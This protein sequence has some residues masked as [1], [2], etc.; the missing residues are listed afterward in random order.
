MFFKK[1]EIHGFKSFCHRTIIS[2]DKALTIIVGPN[3]CGKSNIFDG[4]RWVL[5]E[6]S[7]KSLRGGRMGDVIFNGSATQRPMGFAKVSLTVMNERKILPIDFSE[8]DITRRLF[9]NGEST[10]LLNKKACRLKDITE[11][12][13]DTGAGTS[14]YSIM[15]QG[16]VDQIISSK[17]LERRVIFEEAAGITKYKAKKEEAQRKLQRTEEDHLRITD[18]LVELKKQVGSLKR[19]ANKA[20]RYKELMESL[21]K[22]EMQLL[23]MRFLELVE[24]SK[25]VESN[26]DAKSNELIEVNTIITKLEADQSETSI[27]SETVN[28]KLLESTNSKFEI[29]NNIEKCQSSL[30]LNN[31][32]IKNIEELVEKLT[33][34]VSQLK[35]QEKIQVE[36]IAKLSKESEELE[37][38]IKEEDEKHTEILKRF[39]VSKEALRDKIELKSSLVVQIRDKQISINN[40]N[41]ELEVSAK[42]NTQYSGEKKILEKQKKEVGDKLTEVKAFLDEER[43]DIQS[44]N[45]EISNCEK[46]E[47]KIDEKV[48]SLSESIKQSDQKL[49]ELYSEKRTFES[50]LKAL[51]E[52]QESYAGFSKGVKTVLSATQNGSLKGIC[53]V[54]ASLITTEEKYEIAIESALGSGMQ[55]I[56]TENSED[57]KNA[58]DYLRSKNAGKATFL[59]LD[60]IEPFKTKKTSDIENQQGVLGWA[61]DLVEFDDKFKKIA[62]YLLG[63]VVIVETLE[64][65]I[66]LEK[67]GIR[68]R[69]VSLEGDILNP[70]GSM[71]GGSYIKSGI[72]GRERELK[73]YSR[74]VSRLEGTI[75]NLQKEVDSEK[76]KLN[77]L[78]E[79]KI[80]LKNNIQKFALVK[81]SKLKD[82]DKVITD[83]NN[84]E[85]QLVEIDNKIKEVDENINKL[86][87][88]NKDLLSKIE[89]SKNELEQIQKQHL[90]LEQ[91]TLGKDT[92][93]DELNKAI[94]EIKVHIASFKERKEATLNKV[95]YLEQ[96]V[97]DSYRLVAEK[98][99]EIESLS[100]KKEEISSEIEKSKK[101]LEELNEE[102]KRFEE[103]CASLNEEKE[104]VIEG[105]NKLSSEISEQQRNKNILQNELHEIDV[106]KTEL[107]VQ[108]DNIKNQAEEKFLKNF[109]DIS[110]E[111][112]QVDRNTDEIY[113]EI[114]NI[115][116]KVEAMGPVNLLAIEEYKELKE[117]YDFMIEQE[118]DL[119]E[120]KDTLI[121]TIKKIDETITEMFQKSFSVVREHF[122]DTFRRLF[123]GGQADLVLTDSENILDAGV[124]IVAR[125][126]GKKLQN[127]NLLSGGEKALT[128]IALLFAL[129]LE[130]PS[131]FCVLD[132]IDAPLD[133]ANIDRF[134][135]L[136]KEFSKTTQFIIITHNKQT[137]EL[138]DTLY[139]VT[140][141]EPG[142]SK[143][144]SVKLT[145][146]DDKLLVG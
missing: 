47:V 91:E 138:A 116:E 88:Q 131:P 14:A 83:I 126:P 76:E 112:E 98:E 19:Q 26:F 132:E 104:S 93:L 53:D 49:S 99:K 75:N 40:L 23:Y 12:L 29:T 96:E 32:Q 25:E 118:K 90:Q 58:I 129:F 101:K 30:E 137:M 119:L 85:N 144:I 97:Q 143:L 94:T 4:I 125:P 13:M 2:F 38:K 62:E 84:L 52:L 6:Q 127:I 65:G 95:G 7:A 39:E 31:S 134:K 110:E 130:K 107:K 145:E 37:S 106:K 48:G 135:K 60:L 22:L 73:K 79:R 1:I 18:I 146:I 113:E 136:I 16:K 35:E 46:E 55:N 44:I 69:Y 117:R 68:H 80:D 34:E 115:R 10:Y 9:T 67:K 3:G 33:K 15:E 121:K 139:G 100:K 122:K 57:A 36:E 114:T 5:G 71:I 8:I 42:F 108:L 20:E 50:K 24:K 64:D 28:K 51:M 11:L 86:E 141:E 63:N 45:A 61:I 133:D 105:L 89:E 120:A 27:Q 66:R 128:A 103:I 82:I 78:N 102:Q 41:N 21:K 74:N 140:M 109:D 111:I 142:V 77:N 59:P 87:S 17:P 43:E 72:L 70:G 81:V 123:G 56:V 92:E 54:V 124:D